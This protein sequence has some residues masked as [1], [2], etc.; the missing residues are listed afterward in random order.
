M[1]LYCLLWSEINTDSIVSMD[2]YLWIEW[3]YPSLPPPPA[4]PLFLLQPSYENKHIYIIMFTWQFRDCSSRSYFLVLLSV[5][6]LNICNT[7]YINTKYTSILHQYLEFHLPLYVWSNGNMKLGGRDRSMNWIRIWTHFIF[8]QSTA[9][10]LNHFTFWEAVKSFKKS[11]RYNFT[12][13][14][15]DS[16]LCDLQLANVQVGNH[17]AEANRAFTRG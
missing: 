10:V 16:L 3:R 17:S 14:S 8:T 15:I 13:R 6:V 5:V 1:F 9:V 4:L 2:T 12:P 11:W 7:F